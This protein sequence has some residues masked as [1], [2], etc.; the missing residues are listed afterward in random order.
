MATEYKSSN[1]PVPV[2][3]AVALHALVVVALW[4]ALLITFHNDNH[5]KGAKLWIAVVWVLAIVFWTPRL[6]PMLTMRTAVSVAAD[7]T[8]RLQGISG[9]SVHR[10]SDLQ[11]LTYGPQYSRSALLFGQWAVF[12]FGDQ[13]TERVPVGATSRFVPFLKAFRE[14]RPSFTFDNRWEL[15]LR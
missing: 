15:A 3:A 11:N 1:L 13:G 8:L 5:P 4:A 10:V 2:R 7:G 12:D 6:V 9:T 14:Q